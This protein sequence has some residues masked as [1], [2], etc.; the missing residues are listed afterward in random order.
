MGVKSLPRELTGGGDS[1]C[2]LGSLPRRRKLLPRMLMTVVMQETVE[3]GCND[4]LV[5]KEL[6][7]VG[8]GL[9]GR[10]DGAGLLVAVGHEAIKEIALLPVD[11]R[12]P[13]LVH[14]HQ[15]R[16]VI[17]PTTTG[18]ARFL[19]LLELLD[20]VLHG[21]EGDAH[22]RWTCLHRQGHRQVGLAY[23]GRSKKDHVALVTNEPE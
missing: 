3:D 5:V 23:A 1:I 10:Q 12:I 2:S 7:P 13:N 22:P 18:T 8:E 14:D 20:Q 21:G 4:D 11:G 17:T 15:G 9:V 6:G 16:F 19:V